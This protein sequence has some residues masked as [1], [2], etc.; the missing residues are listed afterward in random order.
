MLNFVYVYCLYLLKIANVPDTYIQFML[1][2]FIS[3]Q[4]RIVYRVAYS[5]GRKKF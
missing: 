5:I 1:I 3:G 2:T 4:L